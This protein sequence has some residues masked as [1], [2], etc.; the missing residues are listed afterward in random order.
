[1]SALDQSAILRKKFEDSDDA[2]E[3]EMHQRK[4]RMAYADSEAKKYRRT[5]KEPVT[6]LRGE[7]AIPRKEKQIREM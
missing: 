2:R 1:M 5:L 7:D 6:L 3:Y 4:K